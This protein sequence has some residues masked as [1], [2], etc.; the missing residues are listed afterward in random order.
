[1]IRTW[2]SH[3]STAIVRTTGFFRSCW[4]G[5]AYRF[6]IFGWPRRQPQSLRLDSASPIKIMFYPLT[7]SRDLLWTLK[8]VSFPFKVGS[9][10]FLNFSKPRKVWL[11][12][13]VNSTTLDLRSRFWRTA[14]ASSTVPY[15]G[16]SYRLRSS[17]LMFSGKFTL[18]NPV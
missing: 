15:S 1:M 3:R 16:K 18:E 11:L 4:E 9:C 17:S 10:D 2:N 12:P 13:P 5:S 7:P 8:L 6:S 14:R